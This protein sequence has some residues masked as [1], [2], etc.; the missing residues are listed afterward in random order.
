LV[1]N[2]T[3]KGIANMG[4]RPTVGGTSP[5]LEIHIFDFNEEIYGERIE[6]E[7]FKKI[8]DEQKFDNLDKL[9]EQINLDIVKTRKF[10]S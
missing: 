8:R 1:K 3:F 10:F 2:E 4:V 5:V 9:K 7:F 6:V